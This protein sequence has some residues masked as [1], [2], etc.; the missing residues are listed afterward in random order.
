MKAQDK[1]VLLRL[2]LTKIIEVEQEAKKQGYMFNAQAAIKAAAALA[3][4]GL[5]RTK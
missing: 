5:E 3:S 1:I 4:E 2:Y